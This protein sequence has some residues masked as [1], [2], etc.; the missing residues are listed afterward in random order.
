MLGIFTG[1]PR[2]VEIHGHRLVRA[3]V[4]IAERTFQ[5]GDDNLVPRQYACLHFSVD[6]GLI[7]TA[8]VFVLRRHRG[9]NRFF[10]RGDRPGRDGVVVVGDAGHGVLAGFRGLNGE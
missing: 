3:G 1:D 7:I 9:D 2:A 4:L 5:V 6:C 8:I 10:I